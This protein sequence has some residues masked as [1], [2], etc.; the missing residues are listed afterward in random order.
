MKNIFEMDAKGNATDIEKR[1]Q[2]WKTPMDLGIRLYSL[3]NSTGEEYNLTDREYSLL[4]SVTDVGLEREI[5]YQQVGDH[6]VILENKPKQKSIEGTITFIGGDL[7]AKY[8]DFVKFCSFIPLTL[9]YLR[10]GEPNDDGEVAYEEFHRRCVLSKSTKTEISKLHT[11]DTTVTFSCLTPWYKIITPT[12]TGTVDNSESID[13]RLWRRYRFNETELASIISELNITKQP[14]AVTEADIIKAAGTAAQSYVSKLEKTSGYRYTRNHGRRYQNMDDEQS[15]AWAWD[16]V[17]N[18]VF[19]SYTAI[20]NT[21]SVDINSNAGCP[22]ILKIAGPATNPEWTVSG[23]DGTSIHGKVN[24]TVS[25]GQWLV[26]DSVARPYE[27]YLQNIDGTR[28]N[29]YQ[30]SDF[31][32]DRFILFPYGKNCRLSVSDSAARSLTMSLEVYEEYD[33][34]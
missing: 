5:T 23:P 12:G 27:I 1:N 13:E 22:A 4:H 7:Y 34:V 29:M 10:K 24:V 19:Y 17:A 14:N 15:R 16:D 28:I 25:T 21:L 2:A 18:G 26:I 6:F 11:L 8:H 9:N 20:K 33:S 3:T 32:T 30:G 31:T